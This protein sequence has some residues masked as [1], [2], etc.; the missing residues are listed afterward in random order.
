MVGVK[1]GAITIGGL[2]LGTVITI[3]SIGYQMYSANKMKKK[4]RAQMAAAAAEAEKRKGFRLPTR[5]EITYLPVAYGKQMVGGVE[6]AHRTNNTY[7]GG[8]G[9]TVF[10]TD[11]NS[12]SQSGSK[13]EFLG[14]Q[15]ALCHSGI[16]GVV[17]VD[18]NESRFNYVKA[19]FN[20]RF[21]TYSTGGTADSASTNFGFPSTNKFSNCAWVSS[22]YKLNR[23]E[24]NYNG[25]PQSQFILK[26]QKIHSIVRSGSVGNY[27]YALSASKTFSNNPAL[28]LLDYLI[29]SEYGRGLPVVNNVPPDIDLETFYHAAEVCN[30]TVKTAAVIGGRV[31]GVKPFQE[32][33]SLSQFPNITSGTSAPADENRTAEDLGGYIY[34]AADTGIFYSWSG[35]SYS[36]TTVNTRN[37]PLYECNMS[38]D[39]SASIRTNIESILDTMGLAE[40]T[41]S[42]EG[43][44]KLLLEYP[45]QTAAEISAGSNEC[46]AV[47]ALVAPEH[48]F[49][50][51]DVINKELEIS[52]PAAN[53]RYNQV[54]VQFANEHEDFKEDSITFPKTGSSV[55]NTFLTEDNQQPFTADISGTGITDPYHALAKAEQEVRQSREMKTMSITVG[56]AGFSLEPG[57]YISLY[58]SLAGIGASVSNPEVF[59]IF[60][61]KFQDN[62]TVKLEAY[63]FKHTMLAW[64]VPDHI[65]YISPPEFDFTVE[66][67]TNF[68]TTPGTLIGADG[69]VIPYVDVAWNHTGA[70]Q[71]ELQYKKT[72]D[73]NYTSVFTRLTSHRILNTETG[74]D[75]DIRVR[76]SNASGSTSAGY[77]STTTTVNAKTTAPGAPTFV[78]GNVVGIYKGFD[79]SWI[80]PNDKDY[81][82]VEIWESPDNIFSNA[83][84]VGTSIGSSFVRNN[85]GTNVTK[86]YWVRSVDTTGNFSGYI[87]PQTATT[88]FIDNN[89]FETGIRDLFEDQGL[90]A[91]VSVSSLPTSPAP[92]AGDTVFLTTDGKLYR[93]SGS[94]WVVI[95]SEVDGADITG[96]IS[97]TQIS[98][99][100]ITTDKIAANAI[101]GSKI[102]ANTITSGLL[103]TSGIITNTAQINDGII[104][105]AKIGNLA[106]DAAKI[107]DLTVSRIKITDG[108][109]ADLGVTSAGNR[110][111]TRPY[112]TPM[113]GTSI[114]GYGSHNILHTLTVPVVQSV[115]IFFNFFMVYREA[116]GAYG[117]PVNTKF[118]EVQVTLQRV[119]N[120]VAQTSSYVSAVVNTQSFYRPNG[121]FRGG[122][123]QFS[124]NDVAVPTSSGNH[125]FQVKL[126]GAVKNMSNGETDYTSAN[127]NRTLIYRSFFSI[128]SIVK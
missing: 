43:K 95:L 89:S 83:V 125:T 36:I 44:Y 33:S 106:V 124:V 40:L 98:D 22:F 63:C 68:S 55:H 96:T 29:S 6:A 25:I 48:R 46:A 5:G 54:T 116:G 101:T 61:V 57:D 69:T 110:T 119:I 122:S 107:T 9:G 62:L 92:S 58:S 114:N 24:V 91:I 39:T 16:E 103:A 65:A 38:L 113:P 13:N 108:A 34:K 66:D 21:H 111:I 80:P 30:T 50:E 64:N 99:N 74:V 112:L 19:K 32:Y 105:N 53:D 97:E 49:T 51:D 4:M 88:E 72:T 52:W 79:I 85:L 73:S 20:H 18:V 12:S 81:S 35:G 104:T 23:D 123:G 86:F 87:G 127:E 60:S 93:Y 56:T 77:A 128:Q 70:Y 102:T 121:Y 42:S 11:F 8:S 100:A 26:G 1:A 27:T 118:H 120:G 15:V 17:D 28:V 10:S 45:Q 90:N 76:A 109:V 84:K 59:K 47:L 75:Y 117:L 115:P 3:T 2:S 41:W 126:A 71:F 94:A 31:N 37:L 78:S 67:P 7:P 82:G 14:V